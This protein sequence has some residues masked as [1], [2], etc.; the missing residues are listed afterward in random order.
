VQFAPTDLEDAQLAPVSWVNFL[1]FLGAEH[2]CADVVNPQ[3][4]DGDGL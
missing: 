3:H 2:L 1:A 4:R